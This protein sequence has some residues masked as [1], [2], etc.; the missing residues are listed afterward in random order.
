MLPYIPCLHIL[1]FHSLLP[2]H[3]SSLTYI[4][5]SST[6]SGHGVIQA[7]PTYPGVPQSLAMVLSKP[8]IHIMEFHSL[9][10]WCYPS[11]SLTYIS[12]SSTGCCHGAIQAL[13]TCPGVSQA[14]AMVLSKPYLHILEFHGLLPWCY[15]S[16]T[17]I[18]WSSTGCCYGA[19]QALPTY[20]G[21]SKA[22]A[23]VLYKALPTYPGVPQAVVMVLSKPYLHV[24]E[25]HRLLP[26][27]YP[28]LAYI[29]W[30]SMGC[31]H[32]AI[33]AL[34]TYPGVPQA[35]A[36]VL[37]KPYLH[38][39]E[40]QRL[41]PWCYTKPYLHILEFH[42][43]LLWCSPSLTYISWSFTGCC[44]GAI[45]AL[46][47][48]PGVP[49]AVAMVL[50]KPYLHILEFH[51]LLLWCSPSLTYIS[52]SSTGCCYGALQALPTY[53]GV[54]QAV[55][56]VLSKPYLHI[57]GFHRLLLWC[58]PSLTYISWGS[59]GCCHGARFFC[60]GETKITDHDLG[61]FCGAV[62]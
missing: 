46:P 56:I 32:G 31:C 24:L 62:V 47:T 10:P 57:L 61:I 38:I 22:V 28:S 45:Q 55:A 16:L 34:P 39:L 3:H 25:F 15:P 18:S 11:I 17:Y 9:L 58:S 5:W 54:P 50:S 59:T 49:Q 44:H 30:S 51:R 29:S 33:Q 8:H 4:S 60:L 6:I 19:L 23:M 1:G 20:P 27:S 43:L 42:R 14:V 7:L 48:Y 53:P 35:V 12:W 21:V 37:S 40:F 41:L 2:W 36:M 13:P 26:W 52:W